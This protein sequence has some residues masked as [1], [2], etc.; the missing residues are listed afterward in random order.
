MAEDQDELDDSEDEAGS[1]PVSKKWNWSPDQDRHAVEMQAVTACRQA[2]EGLRRGLE[3][4]VEA[5]TKEEVI[6]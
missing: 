5:L 1:R 4:F 6:V 3:D 2:V